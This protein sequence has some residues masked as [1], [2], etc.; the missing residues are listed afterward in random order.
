MKIIVSNEDFDVGKELAALKSDPK[1]GA[2]VMFVGT[3]RDI[4]GN[5]QIESMT[6]EHYPAMTEKSLEK[7]VEEAR[8]RWDVLD[9]TVIHRVGELKISDQIVFVGVSSMHRG[10]AFDACEFIIDYLK[11]EAPFWK[12]EMSGGKGEWVDA[13]ESDEKAME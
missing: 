12:K 13:R 6:L 9:V 8:D 4:S 3:V 5:R 10:E 1:A 2:V 7:I 11:T